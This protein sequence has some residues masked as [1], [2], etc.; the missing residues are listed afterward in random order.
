MKDDSLFTSQ[1]NIQ[2]KSRN[3]HHGV[4]APTTTTTTAIIHFCCVGHPDGAG[5]LLERI[6]DE[7]EDAKSEEVE[8]S[9]FR[10]VNMALARELEGEAPAVARRKSAVAAIEALVATQLAWLRGSPPQDQANTMSSQPSLADAVI[11]VLREVE[12]ISTASTA[13]AHQ[14]QQQTQ[15]P[16]STPSADNERGDDHDDSGAGRHKSL[17]KDRQRAYST[18]P[19]SQPRVAN[20][21]PQLGGSAEGAGFLGPQGMSGEAEPV[22]PPN[23]SDGPEARSSDLASALMRAEQGAQGAVSGTPSL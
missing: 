13:A 16:K 2:S 23:S 12:V 11:A 7:L 3:H 17:D 10:E 20:G 18:L 9:R 1:T 15:P 21:L 5:A 6:T 4:P 8:L 22:C 19:M 14:Q